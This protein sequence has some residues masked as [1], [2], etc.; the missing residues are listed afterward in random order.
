MGRSRGPRGQT[1]KTFVEQAYQAIKQGVLDNT[2]P[3][4]YQATE[5]ELADLLGMSRTPV[6]EALIRLQ[7]QGLIELIPRRGMRVLP[8]SAE[9]MIEIYQIQTALE[10]AAVPLL[11]HRRPSVRTLAPLNQTVEDMEAALDQD[12]LD[13]WAEADAKFHQTLVEL[14]GNKRLAQMAAGLADQ[15][16]R[17]RMMTL[18]LRPRPVGSTQAHRELLAAIVNG[19]ELKA[20]EIHLS[21]RRQISIALI[22]HLRRYRLSQ[23]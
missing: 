5:V 8:L 6:R 23:L 22:E 13:A 1:G 20:H 3:P 16:Y 21:H 7:D 19:D 11:I 2:Y 17:A 4:G 14:C 10:L 12:D 9:D 15:V 18:A